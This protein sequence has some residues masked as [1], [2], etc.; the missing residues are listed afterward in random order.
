MAIAYAAPMGGTLDRNPSRLGRPT[1]PTTVSANGS[2]PARACREHTSSGSVRLT[3]RARL[4]VLLLVTAAVVILGPWRAIASSPEGVAPQGWSTVVVQPG[5]TLWT[6]AEDMDP[7]G[8]PRV[9][10]A[11]I[12]QANS[13][14]SSALSPGQVLVVPAS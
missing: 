11:E 10:V 3:R 14:A 8:D 7:T 2:V 12:K 9:I 4:I 13:L 1:R 5:D 6:L